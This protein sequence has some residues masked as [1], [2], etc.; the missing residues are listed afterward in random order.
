MIEMQREMEEQIRV[1]RFDITPGSMRAASSEDLVA[2]GGGK[3]TGSVQSWE[4]H[5]RSPDCL[6]RGFEAPVVRH[7]QVSVTSR[8]PPLIV[9]VCPISRGIFS[10]DRASW[11]G[12]FVPPSRQPRSFVFRAEKPPPAKEIMACTLESSTV[13]TYGVPE[14][15]D[16]S[17]SIRIFSTFQSEIRYPTTHWS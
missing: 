11:R 12:C 1:G 8:Q 5:V 16:L 10:T 17:F 14:L 4:R 2:S 15:N 3:R 9:T 6:A 7:I 13:G